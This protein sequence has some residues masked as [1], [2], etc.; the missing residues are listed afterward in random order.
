[1]EA[2][3]GTCK[4][5]VC[6]LIY[7]PLQMQ[8]RVHSCISYCMH[9]TEQSKGLSHNCKVAGWS[10]TTITYLVCPQTRHFICI[11]SAHQA[12][13]GTNLCQGLTA[14]APQLPEIRAN[15]MS[16]MVRRIELTLC[17]CIKMCGHQ[18]HVLDFPKIVRTHSFLLFSC[19][20]GKS[21]DISIQGLQFH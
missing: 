11:V 5:K 1:M 17:A 4:P 12:A 20:K 10:P 7:I 18:G 9:M 8:T 21:E 13:V 15:F 14:M 6:C 16:L 2:V 3:K 19:H